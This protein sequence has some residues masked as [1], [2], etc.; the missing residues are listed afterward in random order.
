MYG[1]W[2][3]PRMGAHTFDV[4]S[5]LPVEPRAFPDKN[6]ARHPIRATQAAVRFVIPE[7]SWRLPVEE[8]VTA[9]VRLQQGLRPNR[10]PRKAH[11]GSMQP[12][13]RDRKPWPH[14]ERGRPVAEP[15]RSFRDLRL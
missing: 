10:Q 6:P 7:N 14:T 2:R 3:F 9:P 5:P 12:L 11:M 13:Y 1:G 15:L 4:T 8:L